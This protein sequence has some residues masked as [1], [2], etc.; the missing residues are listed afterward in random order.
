[1]NQL[2]IADEFKRLV[3]QRTG[4]DPRDLV[5]PR[6]KSSMTPCVARDG[7]TVVVGH[8]ICVGCEADVRQLHADEL[9]KHSPEVGG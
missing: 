3:H 9:K 1:M 6:E 4:I 7:A 2:E 8:G 5:C